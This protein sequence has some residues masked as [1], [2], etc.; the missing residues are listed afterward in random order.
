[1]AVIKGYTPNA[2]IERFSSAPPEK[3]FKKPNIAF[4]SKIVCNASLST[5]GTGICAT[6]RKTNNKLKV[7]ST[8]LLISFSEIADI[9]DYCRPEITKE[10]IFSVVSGRHPVVE[11]SLFNNSDIKFVGND[12]N[13]N[14]QKRN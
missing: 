7:I 9:W 6:N 4:S 1:M 3:I 8:F 14:D 2:A 12:C 5:P 10:N 11:Q 13:L